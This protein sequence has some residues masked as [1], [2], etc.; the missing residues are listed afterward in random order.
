M[1][2]I[3]GDGVPVGPSEILVELPSLGVVESEIKEDPSVLWVDELVVGVDELGT[4]RA[5][6][7]GNLDEL[8]LKDPLDDLVNEDEVEEEEEF[9]REAIRLANQSGSFGAVL[10]FGGMN[11]GVDE[12]EVETPGGS[13]TLGNAGVGDV[14][15]GILLDCSSVSVKS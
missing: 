2:E 10:G 12:D 4:V 15:C 14:C 1:S 11:L 9:E 7:K 6:G 13:F 8:E 5:G 3:G